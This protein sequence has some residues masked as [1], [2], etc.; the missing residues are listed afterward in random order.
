MKSIQDAVADGIGKVEIEAPP[1]MAD[2]TKQ[3]AEPVAWDGWILREVFFDAGEPI[4]HR[5]PIFAPPSGIVEGAEP[6]A[7]MLRKKSDNFVRGLTASAPSDET[8]AIAE[9]DGD[10]WLPL[11]TATPSDL[12]A[13][14][15]KGIEDLAYSVKIRGEALT[16]SDDEEL[17]SIGEHY[18][19][20]SDEIAA[21][22]AAIPQA[23]EFVVVNRQNLGDLLAVIHHDGGHYAADN[24]LEKAIT[25]AMQVVIDERNAAATNGGK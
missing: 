6:V 12:A 15:E 22:R 9:I 7:W 17:K 5:E 16:A 14:M 25:D 10:E 24:G 3:G 21:I 18:I 11:Y 2:T 1:V 4:S 8:L 23:G 13:G 19:G 20:L